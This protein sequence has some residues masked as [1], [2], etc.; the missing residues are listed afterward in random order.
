MGLRVTK[1]VTK[2]GRYY[3][4]GEVIDDPSSTE[5]SLGRMFGWEQVKDSAPSLGG[6]KK[7][8]LVQIAEDRGLD[9][10]GL[11]KAELLETLS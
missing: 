5:Q 4:K 6:L 8:E 7:S 2:H 3:P 9:V 1:P 11:T 10:S